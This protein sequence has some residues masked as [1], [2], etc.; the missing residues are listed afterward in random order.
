MFLIDRTM[1][2]Q[3]PSEAFG[4]PESLEFYP[5]VELDLNESAWLVVV[6]EAENPDGDANS[7]RLRRMLIS[8]LH[9]ALRVLAL[10]QWKSMQL[11]VL[12]PSYMIAEAEMCLERCLAVFRCEEPDAA[13][14]CTLI[15][16]TR[17]TVL[18]SSLGTPVGKEKVIELV[19]SD[20]AG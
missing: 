4:L 12:L 6:E 3:F 14:P 1:R 18:D 10:P 2:K 19:W 11:F 17:R 15:K 13:G 20:S 8:D 16:T 7:L 5:L 9:E